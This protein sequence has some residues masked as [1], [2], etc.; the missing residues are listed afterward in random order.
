[1]VPAVAIRGYKLL[2]IIV[3]IVIAIM[4]IAKHTP[5]P[6]PTPRVRVQ[7]T[8]AVRSHL[9]WDVHRLRTSSIYSFNFVLPN[10]YFVTKIGAKGYEAT[11][12][13]VVITG[14]ARG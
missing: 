12:R 6:N 14:V 4:I 9:S 13:L 1:M 3:C 7:H 10:N 5:C 2:L 8:N 11:S